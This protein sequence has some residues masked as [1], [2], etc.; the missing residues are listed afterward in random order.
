VNKGH[1]AS[2]RSSIALIDDDFR[3]DR[4]E[5][6]SRMPPKKGLSF[7]NSHHQSSSL[8]IIQQKKAN[9]QKKMSVFRPIE[10]HAP[11]DGVKIKKLSDHFSMVSQMN[12]EN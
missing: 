9:Q 10:C 8:K 11:D 7:S 1:N 12:S 2:K 6:L 5:S 3:I 4:I